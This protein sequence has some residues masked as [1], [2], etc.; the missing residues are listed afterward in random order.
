MFRFLLA[1]AL[2]AAGPLT[3]AD[4]TGGWTGR[5]E[6]SGG[7]VPIYLTLNQHG[8]EVSGNLTAGE[9][10]TQAP[11]QKA[12][13]HGDVLIFEVQDNTGKLT[14][15]D[16]TFTVSRLPIVDR[17]ITLKGHR[18]AGDTVSRVILYPTGQDRKYTYTGITAAPVVI[19]KVDPEYT[20][21]ARA[22]KVQ[23]SVLLEVEIEPNGRV[24]RDGVRVL[25]ALGMGL[26]EKALEAVLLWRFKPGLRDGQPVAVRATIEM[27]FRLEGR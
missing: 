20:E 22:A 6:T 13:V 5:M 25:R 4:F 1:M 24:A 9:D 2:G 21:Q 26:D 16:L 18:S 19:H 27:A 8:A 23:G 17:E 14:R 10:N 12:E 3:A 7:P 11:I 15:F